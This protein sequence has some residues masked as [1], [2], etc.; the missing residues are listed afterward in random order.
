MSLFKEVVDLGIEYDHHS[1][2][3]YVP[4]TP[5]VRDLIK[6]H[7]IPTNLVEP[8]RC[9]RTGKPMLSIYFHYEPWWKK[10]GWDSN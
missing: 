5:E 4:N 7:G 10:I 3:L 8:F 1:S 9:N 6:K 2:D